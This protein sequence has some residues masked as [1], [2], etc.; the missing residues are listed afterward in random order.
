MATGTTGDLGSPE[1]EFNFPL[2][3]YQVMCIVR[4][5]ACVVSRVLKPLWLAGAADMASSHN[6]GFILPTVKRLLGVKVRLCRLVSY[7]GLHCKPL[8]AARVPAALKMCCAA[9]SVEVLCLHVGSVAR[10]C[11]QYSF[12]FP[13]T[14]F[15]LVLQYCIQNSAYFLL[16]KMITLSL[17]HI[18]HMHT[19][20]PSQ[21][22]LPQRHL[23]LGKARWWMQ[24]GG[25]YACA[26]F[27]VRLGMRMNGIKGEWRE[28]YALYC[29]CVCAYLCVLFCSIPDVGS[30]FLFSPCIYLCSL[31]CRLPVSSAHLCV[32]RFAVEMLSAV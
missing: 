6:G 4:L 28:E 1:V 10:I 29:M 27:C 7:D 18:A 8:P 13:C 20:S 21:L 16:D 23:S 14:I 11:G 19:E 9:F 24:V 31:A 32:C 3:L 17:A 26:H 25:W 5:G 2:V 30:Y 22:T 12:F 15:C